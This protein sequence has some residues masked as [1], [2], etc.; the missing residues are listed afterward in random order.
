VEVRPARTGDEPAIAEVH[1]RTWQAAY[2][3]QVPDAFLDS[4]SIERRTRG[5]SQIIAQ[6]APPAEAFVL[7]DDGQVVGFAH[8]A[9]SRDDDADENVGELTAIYVSRAFWGTGAGTLLL[10]RALAGLRDAGFS[11]ATLWVLEANGRARRFY[12]SAD[13]ELDEATKVDARDGFELHEVRYRR[14]IRC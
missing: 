11:R 12:E 1:V 9:P 14:D 3:G 8:I 6:S 10:E 4:L 2:R 7:E 5:W 13:W